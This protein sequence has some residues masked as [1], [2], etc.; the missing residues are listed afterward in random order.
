MT[1]RITMFLV[2]GV[3]ALGIFLG[4]TNNNDP[5]GSKTPDLLNT[6]GNIV[7]NIGNPN[8]P[9]SAITFVD[10]LNGAN[11]T[12]ALKARGYKV[13]YRGV[14]AQG[15]TAT[16]FQGGTSWPAFNGPSTGYVMANFNVVTG[17]NNIDSWLVSPKM[18]ISAGDSLMFWE[19]SVTANPFPDSMRV[20]YS[21]AGDSTPEAG[22]WVELGR[23][24]NTVSGSWAQRKYRMATAGTNGRFALRYNVVNGGPLG[25]NSNLIGVDMITVS[26]SGA[27]PPVCSYSWAAQ[28]SGTTSLLYTVSAVS[29]LVG[30]AGGAAGVVRKTVNGGTT[31]TDGNTTPGVISGDIYNIYA[32]SANDAICTTSPAATFIYKTTN[33]GTT[34]TQVY[35]LAGGFINALQMVS[36]TVGYG[37]GDPVAGKWT[38]VKTTDAGSTWARMATEPAVIGGDAGWNNS[39][40]AI[41]SDLWFGTNG[42][43][44]YH[45]S[46]AGLTWA[47]AATTG[48]LNTYA[49]HYNSLTTGLAGGTAMVKSTNGGTSYSAAAAPGTAGNLNGIYGAGSDWWAIRS[50]TEVFRSTNGATSWASAYTQTGATFQ[51]IDLVVVA[52]CPQG[53]VVGSAGVIAKMSTTTGV[54]SIGVEVPE[55]FLLKQNYP[56]PFN[57]T[58]NINFSI[59]KSGLVSLKVYDM[60]GK[61]VATLI[62]EVK[63]AGNY[64]VGFNAANLPSG[65]YFYRLESGS[66][67]ETKKMLL[68]K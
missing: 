58:T 49:V 26:G 57:P 40:V 63:N 27:P 18:N 53:W 65:A 29:N 19:R 23:F 22:S 51:D 33:G 34:W 4:F 28:T 50:G 43:K 30:W 61:E 60:V 59:P 6:K 56:N 37:V 45:S 64:L 16:W 31:W 46:D 25:D 15:L 17:T 10:S 20:M 44:V 36:P 39:F 12:T 47:F 48:T 21:A 24:L 7:D 67:V 13:Y 54:S 38:V 9:A 41:G 32:W 52:G 35:T 42:T 8:T 68:I 2:A 62:N 14:G 5:H 66:F 55:S 1:S 11:D 3:M